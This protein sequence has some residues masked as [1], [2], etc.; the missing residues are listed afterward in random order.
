[1]RVQQ[2]TDQHHIVPPWLRFSWR[3]CYLLLILTGCA[4]SPRLPPK[5]VHHISNPDRS[6]I[7]VV[8]SP[9]PSP[10]S[11]NL[12]FAISPPPLSPT[13]PPAP[14]PTPSPTLLPTVAPTTL[15]LSP[16]PTLALL[17][18]QQ[19][20]ELF[21]EVW[22]IVADHY[23]YPDFGG[24]DWEVIKEQ[25]RPQALTAM[26]SEDF[27]AVLTAMVDELG[28]WHSR[29]ED[30]QT[31][32]MQQ[33]LS[34]GKETYAGIGILT[35]PVPEGLLVTTVFPDSPAAE[36]GIR[37]RDII[38]AVDGQ[39]VDLK[40]PKISGAAGSNVRLKVYSPDGDVRS[41]LLERRAVV[42]RFVPDVSLVPQTHIGYILIQSF[43]AQDMA[44]KVEAA[45]QRLL[46]EHNNR[47]DGLIIDL[48][49]NGG[50]WRT[51]LEGLLAQ[52]V[53]GNVG[54]FYNQRTTYPLTITPGAL[55]D[56]LKATPL[57]V[58]IDEDTESYAE[59][60]AAIL[61]AEQ[62]AQ[63]VGSPS[64][65][66]TETI[67]AYDLDDGSRLWVAQEGFRLPD[68]ADLEGLGVEPDRVFEIN[69]TRFSETHDPHILTAVELIRQQIAGANKEQQ[70]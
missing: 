22:H 69:W 13:L 61:Q 9:S 38:V 21:D 6:A 37:R 27:Y 29:F 51:V 11:G 39:P 20:A 16:T 59:I 17:E 28:D 19:R 30:P 18:Q 5:L 54:R 7:V 44:D 1:M 12:P 55:Y 33:A 40:A 2:T 31:A 52:F 62:R 42:A 68:G 57:V 49:G 25:Y 10:S 64:A 50:G 14:S 35:L 45:L 32:S 65:G 4:L 34:E 66:N 60:F 63:I 36:Q 26:T 58:L 47:L 15:P 41:L 53:Q 67:C 3:V 24:V 48:R 56:Q 46:D 23:L 43:W 8:P 70:Q